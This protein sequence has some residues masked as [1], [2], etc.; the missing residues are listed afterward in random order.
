[1]HEKYT[2][3]EYFGFIALTH[4]T[5]GSFELESDQSSLKIGLYELLGWPPYVFLLSLVKILSKVTKTVTL[6]SIWQNKGHDFR[7]SFSFIKY[8]NDINFHMYYRIRNLNVEPRL[9]ILIL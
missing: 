8:N 6:M 9:A 7:Y 4:L 5:E 2:Y 1:M 3:N